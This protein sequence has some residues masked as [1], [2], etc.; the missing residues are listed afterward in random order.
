MKI[1]TAP[2]TGDELWEMLPMGPRRAL[3]QAAASEFGKRGYHATTTRHIAEHVGMSPAGLYVHY[4]SKAELLFTISR[5]G[6]E[7]VLAE[8]LAAVEGISAPAERVHALVRAFTIWHAVN[9][10]LARVIQYEL[11]SL[12]P[13]HY[14]VVAAIRR[15][16][17]AFAAEEFRPLAGD[18]EALRMHTIAILSLGI[19]VA[20]WYSP[21]RSPDPEELG[22][23]Y[24]DMVGQ[25][26]RR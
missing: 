20:R 15:R 24:A 12:E 2:S 6:H 9:H 13:E 14:K 18:A 16:T 21:G 26:L 10:N 22:R 25:M 4:A 17:E 19:D 7:S 11:R 3:A 1:S 23:A 5:I 8:S